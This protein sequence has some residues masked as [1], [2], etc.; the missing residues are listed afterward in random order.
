MALR[1]CTKGADNTVADVIIQ[2][3]YNPTKNRHEDLKTQ[4]STAVKKH[5]ITSSRYSI[6]VMFSQ[7]T[8]QMKTTSILIVKHLQITCVIIKSTP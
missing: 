1:L 3:D 2:L 7:V 8:S 4:T 6:T 5:G